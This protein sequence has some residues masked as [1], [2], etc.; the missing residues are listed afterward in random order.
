MKVVVLSDTA[1]ADGGAETLS[2][3]MAGLLAQR[4]VAV[5]YVAGD[6]ST[7]E[8]LASLGVDVMPI[9]AQRV[10]P[11]SHLP[12]LT[13]AIYNSRVRTYLDRFISER[14]DAETIY[15][16]HTWSKAL[17]PAAFQALAPVADRVVIHAHDFFLTCPNANYFNF[18]TEAPCGQ[19]PMTLGC[20]TTACSKRSLSDK[21]WRVTRGM[22]LNR[23]LDRRMG[24]R[25]LMVHDDM[26]DNFVAGG[27]DSKR[28]TTIPNPSIPFTS[29][30]VDPV[31]SKRFLFVGRLSRE[32]GPDL[33]C[34]AATMAGVDLTVVG[35]GEMRSALEA[36]Y[37]NVQFVGWRRK[38]ELEP[39]ARDA[40]AMLLSSRSPEPFGLAVPEA[41]GCGLPVMAASSA[42]L[43]ADLERLGCGE[44]VDVLD[45]PGFAARIAALSVDDAR[46]GEMSRRALET[47]Q[48]ISPSPDKW[49]E[50]I[51]R[52][53][54]KILAEQ[55]PSSAA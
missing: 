38:D 54:T 51:L 25:I 49:V 2:V 47:Y 24:W 12:A 53:Y 3:L 30:A 48:Q 26:R 52:E 23:I 22:I 42:F 35:D 20:L 16:V 45:T 50:L 19:V 40:R 14:D 27:F 17:S 46:V 37:P 18:K 21:A 7:G 39:F 28:L 13:A 8:E 33:A 10:S 44:S 1:I 55:A 29:S 31:A 34:A 43:A 5:T 15:H 41:L 9:G 11:I 32:K 4:G 36:T 6:E